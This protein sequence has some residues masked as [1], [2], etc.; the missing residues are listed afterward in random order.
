MLK[1]LPVQFDRANALFGFVVL[2][3]VFVVYNLTKAPTLSF[4]DCG[5]FIAAASTMGV[6]HPPGSPLFILIGRLFSVIPMTA[7]I[8][9]RVN[10]LSAISNS[11]TALFVY[12]TLVR[13]LKLWFDRDRSNYSRFLTYAGSVSGAFMAA[14]GLTQ[15]TNSVEAEVYGLMMVMLS[16]CV[17][18]TMIYYENQG[19]PLAEKIMILIVFIAVLGI[20]VHLSVFLILPVASLPSATLL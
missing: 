20:G 2:V 12:L 13:L 4:W 18:L 10:L 7:D 9:V 17:W 16:A 6:P 11:F 15:W 19:R 3:T 1:P 8:A 5:E 14:F